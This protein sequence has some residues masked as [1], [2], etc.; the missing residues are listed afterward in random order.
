[1]YGPEYPLQSNKYFR[2]RLLPK[3]LSD[4][5]VFF[6]FHACRFNVK[7]DKT[8]CARVVFNQEYG[9]MNCYTLEASMFGF[10]NAERRTE[11]FQH[12]QYEE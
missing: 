2:C 6:R 4:Q 11:E 9:I 7:E 8:R 12:W 3:L 1:M 5:S 10:L